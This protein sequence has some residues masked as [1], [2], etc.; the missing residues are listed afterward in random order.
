ML[1]EDNYSIKE[2]WDETVSEAYAERDIVSRIDSLIGKLNEVSLEEIDDDVKEKLQELL[3]RVK[4][5]LK[6]SE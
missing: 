1:T 2:A 3:A 6:A 4:S 5:L